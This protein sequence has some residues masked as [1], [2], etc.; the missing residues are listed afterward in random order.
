MEFSE[1]LEI[2]ES[3]DSVRKL[4]GFFLGS[5][6]A[7][8]NTGKTNEEIAEWTL[9]YYNPG[10]KTVIDCCVSEKMLTVGEEMP[11]LKEMEELDIGKVRMA[12]HEAMDVAAA[13]IKKKALNIL[14]SL[15][16]KDAGGK[17]YAVWTIAFVTQ[18]MSVT[19]VDIDSSSKK[20]LKEETTRLI[21]RV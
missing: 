9:L 16:M 11:A 6:F 14:I 19:S 20:I 21:K 1:A 15:H 13:R 17:K 10:K 7:S 2:A 3:N 12:F 18:D 8:I 5:G 4:K